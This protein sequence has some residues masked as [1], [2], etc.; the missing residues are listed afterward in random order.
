[1]GD[2]MNSAATAAPKTLGAAGDY[3]SVVERVRIRVLPDGRLSRED[4][5]RYLGLASKTLSN[6]QLQGKGPRPVKICGRVFY[7]LT[8]LERFVQEQASAA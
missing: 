8:D 3:D 5:A 7:R 2:D 6:L 4:A 1:M